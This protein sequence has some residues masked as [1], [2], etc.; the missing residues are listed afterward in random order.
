MLT[1]LFTAAAACA[2]LASPAAAQTAQAQ[3]DYVFPYFKGNGDGLHL[4]HSTDGLTWRAVRG[5]SVVF[6]ISRPSEEF[7]IAARVSGDRMDGTI[8]RDGAPPEPFSARR[9]Q[10]PSGSI[11]DEETP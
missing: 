5:D 2:V 8:E 6:R 11:E 7:R 1:K 4:A 3:A 10:R 9:A